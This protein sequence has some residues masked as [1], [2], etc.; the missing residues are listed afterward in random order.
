MKTYV[1]N[2]DN[3][4]SD[5]SAFALR[6]DVVSM[7]P[8]KGQ[9]VADVAAGL[10]G[11]AHVI[12][13]AHGDDH[14]NFRWSKSE[15]VSYVEFCKYLPR[16]GIAS[17]VIGSCFGGQALYEDVLKVAPPGTILITMTGPKTLNPDGVIH[18]FSFE[19]KNET[20]PINLFLK[21]MDN[22]DPKEFSDS[23]ESEK[24]QNPIYS[25][26]GKL[27]TDPE[28][29]LPHVIGIGGTPPTTIDLATKC[30]ELKGKEG[31]VHIAAAVARVQAMFDTKHTR[32]TPAPR[33]GHPDE[34]LTTYQSLGSKAERALDD[35][36]AE[37]ARK[38]TRGEPLK[39]I[40]ERR[41]AYALTAAYLD[42]SG[43]LKR[44]VEKQVE[45]AHR[46]ATGAI[47]S[48]GAPLHDGTSIYYAT[49]E[50]KN[51][52]F[53][54]ITHDEQFYINSVAKWLDS[55]PELADKKEK[56]LKDLVSDFSKS[57]GDD[58]IS[59]G[60]AQTLR[61]AGINTRGWERQ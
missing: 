43:A 25:L 26:F 42:E 28:Q 30:T 56:I 14:G 9:S 38:L 15:R 27:V 50:L 17:I 11:P 41:I 3:S 45:S 20:N 34:V 36:I 4:S 29:A 54:G 13:R 5:M 40:E 51:A 18:D 24:K 8:K 49:L 1:L 22:F 6:S 39:D 33:P 61:D 57:S 48:P 7:Y 2:G 32:S 35:H 16:T 19:T 55:H 58:T 59:H 37:V 60:L 47:I 31:D 23:V 12:I 44:I 52:R 21:I 53:K 10:K 46:D